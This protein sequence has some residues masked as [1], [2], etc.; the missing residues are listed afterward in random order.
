MRL[1]SLHATRVVRAA[2]LCAAA[3]AVLVLA[4]S[5]A[6]QAAAEWPQF[7]GDPAH[8][9]AVVG[10]PAPG[11]GQAWSFAFPLGGKDGNSG[12]SPPVITGDLAIAVG[13]DRVVAVDVTTGA[14][15]W[16]VDKG[17]GPPVP[18]ALV[19]VDG[20]DALLFT[21]GLATTS[22]GGTPSASPT[23]TP[24]P[25][26]AAPSATPTVA[27]EPQSASR[28]VA[29][30]LRSRDELWSATLP[31][32]S[33]SGVTV[34]GDRAF[35]GD[36]TGTVTAIDVTTGTALWGVDAGG[37]IESPLAAA[38][39]KVIATPIGDSQTGLAIVALQGSDG[40]QAWRAEPKSAAAAAGPVTVGGGLAF[41]ALADQTVRAFDLD[42]GAER[43]SARL[44][45]PVNI[46]S[47]PAYVDDGLI[48]ADLF[49][50]VYRLDPATGSR[51]WDQA[52]N[53]G[54]YRSPPLILGDQVLVPAVDGQ[55]FAIELST[56]DVIWLSD[57]GAG[58]IRDLV[59]AG[60]VLVGV[61]GGDEA[62]LFALEHDPA[63]PLVR[64]V[65]PTKLNVGRLL[66]W[67][68]AAAVP[69]VVLG[70]AS[71]RFLAARVGPA[72][73]LAVREPDDDEPDDE[74]PDD[75][76]GPD[77]DEGDGA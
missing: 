42:D 34:D 11:Y 61:R 4:G 36:A 30:D 26:T 49:G 43:W 59:P 19:R 53:V 38:D 64:I 73:A 45:A 57:Q 22:A 6:A 31:G 2:A 55:V 23:V 48:V 67:F 18:P 21:E 16:H 54:V 50:Q 25:T 1:T 77:D 33:R 14:E 63:A 44:N 24:Q 17:D 66:G 60:D 71:G 7:Q 28:L 65:T 68:A 51:D 56:G 9:G 5:A 47:G 20:R 35:V 72:P 13:P 69:I 37:R 46:V 76:G 40:A 58:P 52:L 12:L 29:L 70:L 74:G 15:A 8:A 3:L 27:S 39:G 41:A 10:G 75:D 62:G 32:V